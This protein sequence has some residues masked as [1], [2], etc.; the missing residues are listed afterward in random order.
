MPVVGVRLTGLRVSAVPASDQPSTV[1]R[2]RDSP[3]SAPTPNGAMPVSHAESDARGLPR[4]MFFVLPRHSA[5]HTCPDRCRVRGMPYFQTLLR[6]ARRRIST[7]FAVFRSRTCH[8]LRTL[9]SAHQSAAE[10]DVF[11]LQHGVQDLHGR[12]LRQPATFRH[13][14]LGASPAGRTVKREVPGT[15]RS[16]PSANTST[17]TTGRTK[18]PGP[19]QP[20]VNAPAEGKTNR[21]SA[22]NAARDHQRGCRE[23]LL[24]APTR[25]SPEAQAAENAAPPGSTPT[26]ALAAARGPSPVSYATA[27]RTQEP[28]LKQR[29][30]TRW[31]LK[32]HGDPE[33]GRTHPKD[34]VVRLHQLAPPEGAGQDYGHQD[35]PTTESSH[36]VGPREGARCCPV[37]PGPGLRLR[38]GIGGALPQCGATAMRRMHPTAHLPT[39]PALADLI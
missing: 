35:K 22:A 17:S 29:R 37:V 24:H 5:S 30:C 12:F 16:S 36:P 39:I 7:L 19:D 28:S 3:S 34:Q 31:N 38:P 4:V 1:P 8:R 33:L 20:A 14:A 18:A 13:D 15:T 6:L 32:P 23:H 27:Q 2:L 21:L 9:Y 10:T 26:M 11:A 25:Q